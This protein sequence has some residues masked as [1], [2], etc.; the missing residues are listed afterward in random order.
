VKGQGYPSLAKFPEQR[1]F[2]GDGLAG[3]QGR[4]QKRRKRRSRHGDEEFR[5]REQSELGL[6]CG[7]WTE[8]NV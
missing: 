1:R 2:L 8:K 3:R 5:Y 4:P 6:R 7:A